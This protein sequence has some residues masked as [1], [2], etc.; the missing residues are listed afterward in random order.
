VLPLTDYPERFHRLDRVW[1]SGE[2][3]ARSVQSVR[4][5]GRFF[6]VKLEGIAGEA[7]AARLRGRRLELPERKL[8]VL[9]PGHFYL[10]QIVGL[11]ARTP[12]GER[13]GVVTEVLTRPAN[14]VYVVGLDRGGELLVPATREAV[15]A[16]DVEAGVLVV[17]PLPGL[18]VEAEL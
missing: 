18:G 7:D 13:L 16:I 4:E 8:V 2:R 3:T 10:W 1:V 12:N 15:A 11:E 6:L 17:N 14:D 5:H 9:P